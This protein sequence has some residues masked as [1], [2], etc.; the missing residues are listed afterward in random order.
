MN[1]PSLLVDDV[2]NVMKR[3]DLVRET[4][5]QIVKDFGVFNLEISFSGC[6]EE[7]YQELFGQMKEHVKILLDRDASRFF[8]LLY[9]IDVS[10]DDIDRYQRQFYDYPLYAVITELIIH[11]ELKK[12]IT[13]D[14]FRRS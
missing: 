10:Q 3:D 12:V 5:D 14:Y 7:F 4:A 6:L 2:N 1:F 13:R 8:N 11:R 9:R